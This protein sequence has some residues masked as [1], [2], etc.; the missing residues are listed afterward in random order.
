[1]PKEPDFVKTSIKLPRALWRAAHIR[2]MD[3]GVDLQDVIAEALA[4]YL[5]PARRGRS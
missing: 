4:V 2:A 1:M 3:D 5:K